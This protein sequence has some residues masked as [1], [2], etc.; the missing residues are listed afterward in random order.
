MRN[1]ALLEPLPERQDGPESA[2]P[3][4]GVVRV[5]HVINGEHFAGAERVQD[6]LAGGLPGFGFPVGL[7]CLKPVQFPQVRVHREAPLHELP[8]RGRFD[9]R[10]VARLVCLIRNEGYGLLH[11]HTPRALMIAGLASLWTGVP[12]VYHVHS[13]ASRDSTRRWQNRINAGI[14][15]VFL[16]QACALITVSHSLR[17]HVL[18]QGVSPE[19]VMVVPNGVPERT[20]RA[21]RSRDQRHWTIGTVALFRPRK[22]VEVLLEAL[23]QLRAQNLPVQLRA[24]GGFETPDYEQD[25]RRLADRFGVSDAISWTGFT[26]DV[27]R[28]LA[29]I[30]VLVL[31]SLFGEG[32]PM[33]VLEAMAA[34]VPVVATRVEGVP[35][36]IEDGHSGLLVAPGD[37]ADLARALAGLIRGQTDWS[38][39]RQAALERHARQFSDRSMAEG[40]AQV[41]RRILG[42]QRGA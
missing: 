29:Q 5:L 28:E 21:E 42:E 22:G 11:A 36:A 13:P 25:V 34:G 8:M 1:H 6:L 41:Y 31:P 4:A 12:L 26:Q 39:L 27:D 35:E 2:P 33:V 14:E 24:V 19:K 16:R 10:P 37:P 40:V 9:L 30:D 15:R 7:A 38:T 23:A 20:P 32:L 17:E 18:R 3:S